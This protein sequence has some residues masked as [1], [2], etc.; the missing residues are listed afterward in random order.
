MPERNKPRLKIKLMKL[1]YLKRARS[2]PPG[3]KHRIPAPTACCRSVLC[4]VTYN[5]RQITG[6]LQVLY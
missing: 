4:K 2:L 5:A 1:S 3:I 6:D